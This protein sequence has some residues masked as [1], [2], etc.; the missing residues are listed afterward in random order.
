MKCWVNGV[1]T[2]ALSVADRG[3]HY[4]DGFF[5]TVQVAEGALLNWAAHRQRI[6]RSLQTLQMPAALIERLETQLKQEVM[7]QLRDGVLKVL[8]TRGEMHVRGY[9]PHPAGEPTVMIQFFPGLPDP[10]EPA[11]VTISEIAWPE[12]PYL[13]GIKHL[14]RLSQVMAAMHKP[15][16]FDEALMLD[17]RHNVI[18]GIASAVVGRL[19]R[20]FYLPGL[21]VC[22]VRSTTVE[23][24]QVVAREK[25]FQWQVLPLSMH[26]VLQ[27]ESLYLLN[28]VQGVRP[29]MKLKAHV[30]K[31]F[32]P[33]DA[34][35]W[36]TA[37]AQVMREQ[38]WRA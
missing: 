24:L 31:T 1:E 26:R 16:G 14:N 23:A 10:A 38:A 11:V 25:G 37:I 12:M 19:G 18:S 27:M 35:Q 30:E 9:V 28:A 33:E 2:D 34:Q 3:L 29:V 4:G 20:T 21:S 32:C 7:P 5:T 6:E 36:N 15:Q 22:G 8:I 17:G 13:Q